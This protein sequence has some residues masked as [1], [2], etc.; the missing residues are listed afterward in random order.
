MVVVSFTSKFASLLVMVGRAPAA[1]D[2]RRREASS[3]TDIRCGASAP[4][5]ARGGCDAAGVRAGAA[6]TLASV[7]RAL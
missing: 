5:G 6:G 7:E 2:A 4:V 3:A 1:G